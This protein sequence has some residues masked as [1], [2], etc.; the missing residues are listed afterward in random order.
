MGVMKN[1]KAFGEQF[2]M[3]L[4]LYC[5]Y[6]PSATTADVAKINSDD[7]IKR[8]SPASF[9]K[10]PKQIRDQMEQMG[11]MIP[12]VAIDKRPNNLIHGSYAKRGQMDWAV[13]CSQN[14]ESRIVI[15]WGGDPKMKSELRKTKDEDWLQDIGGG[16]YGYSHE[17]G[18]INSTGIKKYVMRH[19]QSSP[20]ITHDGIEES[21]TEKASS[22]L[23]FD[24]E[25]WI[26]LMGS[27]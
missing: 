22:V 5:V 1:K 7:A 13:L 3:G 12:Q 9:S 8:L 16:V 26:K 17:I 19:K 21:F 4:A 23:Y 10:P 15:F 11:C 27:D 14:G 24:Q 6:F 25:K 2:L 20:S 18:T